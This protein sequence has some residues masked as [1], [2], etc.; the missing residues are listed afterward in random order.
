VPEALYHPYS[1]HYRYTYKQHANGDASGT[2]YPTELRGAA[3][4]VAKRARGGA[5]YD[6]AL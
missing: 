2:L 5:A 3:A 1:V 6:L 4:T